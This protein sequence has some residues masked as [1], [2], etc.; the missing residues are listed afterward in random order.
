MWFGSYET[1]FDIENG[2]NLLGW[3]GYFISYWAL[4]MVQWA[5]ELEDEVDDQLTTGSTNKDPWQKKEAEAY[6]QKAQTN[7]KHWAKHWL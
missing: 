7:E 5:L 6:K 3:V 2:F 4:I 1:F